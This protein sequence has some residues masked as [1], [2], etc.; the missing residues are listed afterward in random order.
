MA[1]TKNKA[2]LIGRVGKQ[3]EMRFLANGTAF[4]KFSLATDRNYQKDGEWVNDTDWHN[5][6]CWGALAERVNERVPKGVMVYVEGRIQY[7]S[8]VDNDGVKH[9]MT[10]IVANDV[11]ALEKV[12]VQQEADEEEQLEIPIMAPA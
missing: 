11:T 1:R 4:T 10:K 5:V 2:I 6:E 12:E 7:D 8:W 3:P 9:Y